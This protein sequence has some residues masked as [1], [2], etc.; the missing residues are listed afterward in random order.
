MQQLSEPP[1]GTHFPGSG[2]YDLTVT[3][4]CPLVSLRGQ[5]PRHP[6]PFGASSDWLLPPRAARPHFARPLLQRRER[7]PARPQGP[8]RAEGPRGL[9]TQRDAHLALQ[10]VLHFP[11]VLLVV[12]LQDDLAPAQPQLRVAGTGDPWVRRSQ[13]LHVPWERRWLS[14]C[15]AGHFSRTADAHSLPSGV[16]P[17]D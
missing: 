6:F 13:S 12:V 10:E 2:L 15:P 3:P 16:Q 17:R 14:G 4:S 5:C 11:E 7:G 9:G 1:Q 8:K